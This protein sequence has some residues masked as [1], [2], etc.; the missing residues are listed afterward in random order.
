[1][2]FYQIREL[3]ELY[4]AKVVHTGSRAICENVLDTSD[5]DYVVLMPPCPI[6]SLIIY[7]ILDQEGF[8]EQNFNDLEQVSGDSRTQPF[9]RA[10][11]NV[12]L[13][14][15]Q[16][17]EIELFEKWVEATRTAKE[18]GLCTSRQDRVDHFHKIIYGDEG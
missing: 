18:L 4:Q 8:V 5:D 17:K 11:D 7:F 14:L 6:R 15:I 3:L 16:P 13:I 1:M 9:K 12:N 2:K 10:C